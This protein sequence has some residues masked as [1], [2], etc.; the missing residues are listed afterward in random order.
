[1][2]LVRINVQKCV[3][4]SQEYGSTDEHMVSRV[5]YSIDVDGASKGNYYS[6]IKQVV[7][8]AYSS[9]NMEVSRPHEYRGPYDHN[10]FSD[11]V[12]GYFCKLVSSSGAMISLG[13]ATNVRMRNNTFVVPYHFQFEAEG[14]V[15]SW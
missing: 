12:A 7:G 5:F 3:Q 2:P 9:G 6:D 1:M 4:D 11:E 8:S 14:A 13:G 15:A 10:V